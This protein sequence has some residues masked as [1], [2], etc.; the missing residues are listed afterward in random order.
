MSPETEHQPR[1]EEGYERRDANV[2]G[3]LRF[4]FWMAVVLVVVILGMKWTLDHLSAVSPSGPP[5]TGF[6]EPRALPPEPRLQVQ[7][8]LDLKSFC[9]EQLNMLNSYGWIDQQK[10]IV[11]IPIERAM[12]KLLEQGLPA[13]PAGEIS[14]NEVVEAAKAPEWTVPTPPPTDVGGQCAFVAQPSYPGSSQ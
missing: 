8:H 4:A 1:R 14:P 5:S 10:R 13:R 9:S 3:L 11:H 6:Y 7:P 2:R 12:D